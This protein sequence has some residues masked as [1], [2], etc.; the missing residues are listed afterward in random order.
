MFWRKRE[1]DMQ[2]ELRAHLELEAEEQQ[3]AGATA[4]EARYRARRV[5]GNETRIRES[6]REAWKWHWLEDWMQDLRYALRSLRASP[7]FALVAISSLAFG[8]GA[9]T[10]IFSFV[11][12]LLLKQ[13]PVPDAARLVQV[14]EYRNGTQINS[15]FSYPFIQALDKDARVFDGVAARFTVR[16]NVTEDGF[17]EP[18]DGEVVTDDYFRTL[19]V[20]PA[21]GRLFSGERDA[22]CVISYRAWQ[23][24]F[25][26]DAHIIGRK[27]SLNA[28]LYTVVG[29]TEKGFDGPQLQSRVDMQIPVSKMGDFMGGFFSSKAGEAMWKSARFSWLE[30]VGRLKHGIGMAQAQEAIQA[31]AHAAQPK[32]EKAVFRLSSASQG[33]SQDDR[34]IKPVAVLMGVVALVLLIAC[35][36]VAG[37][38]L[39]RA[40][41]RAKEFAVRLSL[42]ASRWRVVR[43]L[44]VESLVIAA[45][46]GAAGLMLA[47]WIIHTLLAYLNT[48][49]SM[50]DFLQASPDARVVGFSI[51][52][53]LLTAVLFGLA[54]AWQ[55]ARPDVIPELKGAATSQ[56]GGLAMRKF[57]IVFQIALAVVILFSAGLL[58]R[59]LSQLKT[60]DLGFDP[61]RVIT[62][63][64]DPAMN[65]HRPDEA[66]RMFAD[67]LAR[68][69]A[70]PGIR[71]ASLAVISPLSGG[72][73]ALDLDVPG[74]LKKASEAQTDFN[75]VSPDFFKTLNQKM[76][77]GRDFNEHDIKGA[78][79]VAI[80]NQSF[81]AQYMPGVNP[82]GRHMKAGGS[83]TEI[84]GVVRDAR[85]Q[86]LREKQVPLV[87]LAAAQTQN[88]GYTVLVRSALPRQQAIAAIQTSIRA[89]DPKLPIYGIQ[90]LQETI[91]QTISSE[92]VL[93]FLSALFSALATLLCSLGIYGLIAYAVSRRTREIGIRFAVGAQR[94]DVARLFLGE[95]LLLVVVGVIAGI[96]L[97]IAATRALKSLLF[98]VQALDA[99]TMAWTVVIFLAMGLLA[100]LL[101][102]SKA[103][104]IEPL[105]AL[106][107]E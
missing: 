74:H 45:G 91:D 82:I 67:I 36:N 75:M 83:D 17:G 34:Y 30:P 20:R 89:V 76:L 70:Q 79:Q 5:L 33:V 93:S 94:S 4:E 105:E 3:A 41:F 54:P 29:V 52:L 88:S 85:Y 26:S 14:A 56:S 96:P 104:R 40:N 18:L 47:Y 19:Q 100:S 39:A 87:Y 101:P 8:I 99:A 106:R 7:V 46:G 68:L 84:V 77:A 23:D 59:T 32:W 11:N 28:H 90:E 12:A 13:L 64:L 44:M 9:N 58:T 95:S 65:G 51:L 102:V 55:A 22:V 25:S 98:G 92:R 86:Y 81:V 1:T 31:A 43:Q 66:E 62:L 16:V 10:A 73:I 42:G 63:A 80:V 107:Y 49:R 2:R 37:L 48:G 72:M 69:R 38:L 50:N 103:A 78:Q 97:A 57:L 21:M 60:V 61:A 35:A 53:S 71:A 27:L 6:V 15:V 24:R